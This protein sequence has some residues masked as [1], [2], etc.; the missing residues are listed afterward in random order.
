MAAR[1]HWTWS[2]SVKTPFFTHEFNFFLYFDPQLCN[3]ITNHP[4]NLLSS[5]LSSGLH[6]GIVTFFM[7]WVCANCS[8]FFTELGHF[9]WKPHFS[10]M[11]QLFPVFWSTAQIILKTYY[12]LLYHQGYSLVTRHIHIGNAWNAGECLDMMGNAW[13]CLE[14][15]GNE[16]EC[17]GML[18]N[19]W[20]C[21]DML[22]YAW[23]CLRMLGDAWECLGML[24]NAW[25][26]LGMLGT[27]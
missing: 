27:K 23:I 17:L 7:S 21:L 12:P 26:C 16:G 11:N 1:F 19:A 13:K 2:F 18:G 14:M 3:I 8:S 5:S 15:L 22:G 10:H 6:P 9:Q 20:E 4:E 25:E 24:G